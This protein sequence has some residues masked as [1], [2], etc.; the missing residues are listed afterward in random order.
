[1]VR[2]RNS[3]IWAGGTAEALAAGALVAAAVGAGGWAGA[4]VWGTAGENAVKTRAAIEMTLN[5]W[6]LMNSLEA[7][8][9]PR[10]S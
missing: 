5:V 3:I 4:V 2:L 10:M 7:E 8:L 9:L 1:M 6:V